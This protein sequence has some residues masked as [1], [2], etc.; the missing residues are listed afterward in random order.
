MASVWRFFSH[1]DDYADID[2]PAACERLGRALSIPTVDGPSHD[3]TDWAAFDELQA[4]LRT[5][6]PRVFGTADVERVD[7]SLMVTVR[8]SEPGLDPAMF[9]GHMDV[10]PVVEGTEGD[11]THGPFEGFVDDEYVWGRGALDMT[12]QVMGMLEAVEYALGHGWE[13]RRTLVLCL[14][15]DEE[16]L[17]SG[18]RAMGRLLEERGVR[19]AFVVDEGNYRIVD[20]GCYGAPGGHGICVS[21]A[22]KGY[23]DVRLTV[24]GAGGH[25]SNPFGGTS[26][27]V[28]AKAI[29]RI[30]SHDWPVE[31][32]EVDRLLLEALA[33]SITREPLAGWVAGGRASIDAHADE[34]ADYFLHDP[35]LNPFVTTT[36][37]PTMI[38]GGS[39]QA[40][41]MPQD[42]TATIN[43]RILPG[44][45]MDYVMGVVRS[46]VRDLPVEVELLSDVS[47]DPS[48]VSRAD[49]LGFAAVR[50][51]MARYFVDPETARP[52]PLIPSIEKGATDARMYE[53]V[54][55]SCLRVSPFVA[56]DDE[57]DRGVHGTDERITRRSYLQGI[58]FF[59][60]LIEETL[61]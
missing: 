8:G 51:A 1:E 11:W 45:T 25:S 23:A 10:V 3:G 61:L 18:A 31:L 53:C 47:N 41:V 14:G 27:A 38:E 55:D 42:M 50:D 4:F 34:I 15:Q 20:T 2:G 37:A 46:L 58:R 59:V 44:Y 48:R 24:R 28:L 52:V 56:D 26:L 5:S 33:P 6:F 12:D 49:G 43:F 36:C 9:M 54:C 7:H 60:R 35:D 39:Q 57:V 19:L 21:L 13:F 17:Q 29:D 32:V 22:E 40:N 16:T 30:A